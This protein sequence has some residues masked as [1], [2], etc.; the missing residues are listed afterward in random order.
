MERYSFSAHYIRN[1]LNLAKI[2]QKTRDLQ[3]YRQERNLLVF[4]LSETQLICVYPFGV[5]T[6]FGVSDR[7]TVNRHLKRF[8]K[9]A[10]EDAPAA[11]RGEN[12]D[13]IAPEEYAVVIDPGQ[14][15]VVEFDY[16]RFS[17]LSLDDL[18][19]ISHVLAQSVAI[20]F[21]ESKVD[22][23]I[24]RFEKVHR[25]LA[26]KGRLVMNTREVMR[27]IGTSGLNVNFI[28]DKLSLLDKPD[29]AWE[30]KGA[31]ILYDRLRNAFELDDRF[32]SLRFK[33]EFVQESSEMVLDVLQN[34]K[35]AILEIIII[36]L[37]A[38]EVVFYLVTGT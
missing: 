6:L 17:R 22:R 36:L 15:D 4:R 16:A 13:G 14:P 24:A 33:I 34:R 2:A 28:V 32:S 31:E 20:D 21:L 19:L 11:E 3:L 30:E 8:R 18:L 29:V 7:R 1:S 23:A 37:I 27:I 35:S 26:D 12:G 10:E 5:V 38:F 9:F 25:N